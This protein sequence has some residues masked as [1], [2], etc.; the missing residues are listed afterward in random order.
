MGGTGGTGGMGGAGG[1]DRMGG[2]GGADQRPLQATQRPLS[3]Q[4]AQWRVFV[5]FYARAI[6]LQGSHPTVARALVEH[7]TVFEDPWGRA[8]ATTRYALRLVF[9]EDRAGTAAELHELHRGIAGV[10]Y[11]GR[12]YRAWDRDVWT[13]VHLTTAEALIYAL[14]VMCG[15]LARRELEAFYADTRAIGILYGVRERDMPPDL[16]GLRAYVDDGVSSML[17]PNPGTAQLRE[18]LLAGDH[19]R[20]LPVPRP[21]RAALGL[22]L[23]GPTRTLVFGAFPEA[24]RRLWQVRWTPV[25][26]ARYV[27]MLAALRMLTEPLPDRL[28][29]LAP[30]YRALH[31][32]RAD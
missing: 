32:R 15:P 5:P 18:A 29:M 11:D 10:G 7:S 19:L 23:A 9:G 12:P 1:A 25:D 30:A 26:Q 28:R 24:V 2:A 13:W 27:A 8:A 17:R 31:A 4:V 16:C 3:R 21:V 22:A 20:A 6:G 14:D